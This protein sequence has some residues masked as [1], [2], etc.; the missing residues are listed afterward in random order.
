MSMAANVSTLTANF[1]NVRD[2]KKRD[3]PEGAIS[4]MKQ[5]GVE[6]LCRSGMFL[7]FREHSTTVQRIVDDFA[8]SRRFRIDVHAVARFQMSDDA[9]GSDLKRQTV[10][11]G[12][13]AGLNMIDS[14]KPLI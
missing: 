4:L 13:T 5:Q 1:V 3:R 6:N 10:Q 14:H 9:F 8:Y 7:G 12:I 11:F 2:Y